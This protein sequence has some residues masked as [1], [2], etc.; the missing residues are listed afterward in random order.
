MRSA[1]TLSVAFIH[2]S[3]V[4]TILLACRREYLDKGQENIFSW[5][6]NHTNLPVQTFRHRRPVHHTLQC[7]CDTMFRSEK[8]VY[9]SI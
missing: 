5:L 7:S 1:N 6:T 9:Q 8:T 2:R 3:D 4:N